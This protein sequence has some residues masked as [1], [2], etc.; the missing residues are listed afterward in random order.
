MKLVVTIPAL[1][2]EKTIAQV[3]R[4]VPRDIP[5]ID[6]VDAL[7]ADRRGNVCAR[8]WLLGD[9]RVSIFEGAKFDVLHSNLGQHVPRFGCFNG[10]K[11]TWLLPGALDNRV[12]GWVG[13]GL[14][15]QSRNGEWWIRRP[16]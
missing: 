11:F 5:G 1:N 6:E 3:V 7:F 16:A 4:G 10:Q 15:L 2:E 13:E 9:G 12:M 8:G 14:T